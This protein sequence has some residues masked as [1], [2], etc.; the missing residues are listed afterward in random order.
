MDVMKVLM[1]APLLKVPFISCK[2]FCNLTLLGEEDDYTNTSDSISFAPTRS[3]TSTD[4]DDNNRL[5]S[6]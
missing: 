5:R 4:D 2:Y 3:S 6:L 1:E